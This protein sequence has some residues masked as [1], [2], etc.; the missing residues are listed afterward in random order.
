M[1]APVGSSQSHRE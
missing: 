1:Q